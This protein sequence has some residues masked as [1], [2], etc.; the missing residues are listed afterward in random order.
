MYLSKSSVS[1][2]AE[3][4]ESSSPHHSIPRDSGRFARRVASRIRADRGLTARSVALCS[5]LALAGC[6]AVEGLTGTFTGVV[7]REHETAHLICATAAIGE[8]ISVSC[9]RKAPSPGAAQ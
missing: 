1:A 7:V 5:L 2:G 4:F 6:G 9:V 3:R 8:S